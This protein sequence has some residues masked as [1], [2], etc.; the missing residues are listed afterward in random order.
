MMSIKSL[1]VSGGIFDLD[2]KKEQIIKLAKQQ[3]DPKTW[4][5]HS[6]SQKIG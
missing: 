2:Q 3:E 4:S 6:L 1:I 5:D